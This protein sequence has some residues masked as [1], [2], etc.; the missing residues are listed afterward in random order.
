MS[1]WRRWRSARPIERALYL[2]RACAGHDE[3]RRRVE[4]LITAHE[5]PES[6][7]DHAAADVV[8][9]LECDA[10]VDPLVTEQP[11]TVIGPYKLLEPIGEGGCGIVSRVNQ[12]SAEESLTIFDDRQ[13]GVARSL[14]VPFSAEITMLDKSQ[15]GPADV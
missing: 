6:V 14:S 13:I 12:Q 8:G 4:P 2:D 5:R 9:M 10:P 15:K 11:G 7:L 1:S 3:L